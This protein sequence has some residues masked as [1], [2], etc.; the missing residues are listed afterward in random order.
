MNVDF[1]GSTCNEPVR[2][3]KLFG[4][5]DNQDST[6]AYSNLDAPTTWIADVINEEEIEVV[7]TPID[8]CII[9]F[10][11]NSK[12]KESTCDGMLTTKN[13]LFLVELKDQMANWQT[14]A[15][16]QLENTMK[17]ILANH[18]LSQFTYKK[19]FACNK[20]SK[21]FN[22]IENELNLKF[23]RA[24]GFRIDSNRKIVIK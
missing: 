14:E 19:G 8:W 21:R 4:L 23:F 12:K 6:K 15:F 17:L 2:T 5:C 24:Y 7:F 3:N 16:N 10:Q 1:L 22:F 13:S 11:A 9:V 18:D 20:K